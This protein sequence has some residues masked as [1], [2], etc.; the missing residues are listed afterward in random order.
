MAELTLPIT[1]SVNHYWTIYRGRPV[2]TAK[3]RAY[4]DEVAW[5]CLRS[6]LVSPTSAD[7][8]VYLDVYRPAKR[9]DL[10]GFA[11]VALDALQ[12][13]AYK[14]DKQIVGLHMRRFDDKK[15]PR[16]EVKIEEAGQ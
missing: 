12:G 16:V 13:Y 7:V 1:P 8:I 15:N 9:G 10:D 2:L 14:N 5:L 4:K 11:K 6:G 3:A